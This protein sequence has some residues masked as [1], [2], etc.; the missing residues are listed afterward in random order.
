MTHHEP[1]QQSS[2]FADVIEACDGAI[3]SNV[4]YGGASPEE[5]WHV[6]TFKHATE[7][8]D[9]PFGP[10]QYEVQVWEPVPGQPK[11]GLWKYVKCR[12]L[13]EAEATHCRIVA[14]IK[15]GTFKED[16]DA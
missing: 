15:A 10:W 7:R 14:Q 16:E 1:P 3:H 8:D 13:R 4:W 2:T 9:Y 5:S 6:S 12:D 11:R